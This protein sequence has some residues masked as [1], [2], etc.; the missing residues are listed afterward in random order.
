MDKFI[1]IWWTNDTDA[2]AGGDG[3]KGF[4]MV[5]FHSVGA[6]YPAFADIKRL[7]IDAGKSQTPAA[8]FGQELYNRG[9]YNSVII[10][11][12]IATAQKIAGK[13][14]VNADNVRR[15][16]ENL[17]LDAARLKAL[18]S[19]RPRRTVQDDLRRPQQPFRDLRPAV[20]RREMDQGQRPDHPRFRPRCS[21]CSTKPPR[22][23]PKNAGWPARAG[24]STT[25][26]GR[27]LL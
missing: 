13:K 4:K 18:G 2:A 7:V 21:R 23:T 27:P 26:E 17:D 19:R 11:E 20:G 1:A 16:L 12:A 6:N 10:A 3:A 9:V 25:S 15:G 22:L 8:E 14:V 5:S 24:C